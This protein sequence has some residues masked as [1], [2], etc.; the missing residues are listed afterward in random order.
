MKNTGRD[1]KGQSHNNGAEKI[2]LIPDRQI[3]GEFILAKEQR[4]KYQEFYGKAVKASKC[5][6]PPTELVG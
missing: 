6:L 5:A 2:T 3:L 1:L 4:L